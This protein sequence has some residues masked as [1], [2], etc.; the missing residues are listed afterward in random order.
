VEKVIG[1]KVDVDTSEGMKR[2]I[3]RLLSL[4]EK[5]RIQA[6]F[7]VPTGKDHTGWTA[8]RVFTKKGFLKKA[9]RVGV[10]STYGVKTLMYGL[11]LPGPEFARKNR[12]LLSAVTGQGHD[13]GIHGHDHV[14]WHDSIKRL[15]RQRTEQELE[16]SF[17]VF[18]EL[19]SRKPGSFAAPGWVVNSHALRFFS[20]RNL[21]FTSNAR[22]RSPFLPRMGGEMF[23]VLEIPSTLPT[24]DEVVGVAGTEAA[25]LSRFFLQSLSDGLNILTVHTELEG[26]R[27]T[28]FL[29]LFLKEAL[30]KGFTFR[31]LGDIAVDLKAGPS[32]PVCDVEYGLIDGRAGE[33]CLQQ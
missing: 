28:G 26:H 32:L 25:S 9:G 29:E 18:E 23:P 3:P 14:Y 22:G 31:K 6:S 10:V 15:G 27:W 17:A 13:L 12:E 4:F 30:N 11:L 33:V 2:G 24:L 20:E 16:R 21:L 1:I 7:F 5:Y 8:K 19:T